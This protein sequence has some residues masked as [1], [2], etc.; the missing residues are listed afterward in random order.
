ME[1]RITIKGVSTCVTSV[2]IVDYVH[3]VEQKR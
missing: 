1:H 2:G 3:Y